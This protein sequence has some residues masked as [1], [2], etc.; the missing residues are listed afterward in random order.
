MDAPCWA[1]DLGYP[2]SVVAES[3]GA[4]AETGP[5]SS[6]VHY[7]FP[8][9]GNKPPVKVTW[10]D[11]GLLPERPPELP[12]G[13]PMGNENGGAIFVGEKGKIIASDENAQHPRLLPVALA[14]GFPTPP[15]TIPRPESHHQNWIDACKGGEHAGAHFDYAGPLTE[16]ILLGNLSIRTGKKLEWDGPAMKC[17]NV[18]EANAFVHTQYRE[19]WAL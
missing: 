12:A 4:N 6:K 2:T 15:K 19:G 1:L 8:A 9:R 14:E 3:T 13:H 16:I 17:T 7:E 10:Y 5:V 18:P 11:G